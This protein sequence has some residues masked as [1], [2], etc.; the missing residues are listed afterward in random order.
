MTSMAAPETAIHITSQKKEPYCRHDRPTTMTGNRASTTY[1]E[2]GKWHREVN[3]KIEGNISQGKI[4]GKLR[5]SKID[6][7]KISV[8]LREI[9]RKEADFCPSEKN[10]DAASVQSTGTICLLV[11]ANKHAQQRTSFAC[12]DSARRQHRPGI[13]SSGAA[14]A[15]RE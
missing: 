10:F 8:R 11:N 9:S 2:G 6:L 7:S 1:A 4:E 12:Q 13:S 5:L 3:Y 15:I 14:W